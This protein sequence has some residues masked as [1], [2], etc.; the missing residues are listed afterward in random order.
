MDICLEIQQNGFIMQKD[1]PEELATLIYKYI[2][3]P[4]LHQKMAD[5]SIEI[6]NTVHTIENFSQ[7]I[8]KFW[9]GVIDGNFKSV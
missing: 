7:D 5:K 8:G 3:T 9:I 2:T 4:E 6:A 1:T